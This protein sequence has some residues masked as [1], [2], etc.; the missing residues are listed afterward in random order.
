M[1][2]TVTQFKAKCLGI[3]DQVQKE[4]C[5]VRIRKYGKVA[6]ELVPAVEV[7][8]RPI[9]ARSQAQMEIVGDLMES[10]ESWDADA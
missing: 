7:D 4:N 6:A 1:D 5:R 8:G 3:V 2:I 9:W 10:G